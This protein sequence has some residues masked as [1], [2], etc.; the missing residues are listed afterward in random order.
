MKVDIITPLAVIKL[1]IIHAAQ[2][3]RFAKKSLGRSDSISPKGKELSSIIGVLD[4]N[5]LKKLAWNGPAS[6]HDKF[7]QSIP[8]LVD[9]SM[10]RSM[11]Q[12]MD[13]YR[14]GV[15]KQSESTMHTLTKDN[16]SRSDFELDINLVES[17]TVL[18]YASRMINYFFVLRAE[19][20][21]E[22]EAGRISETICRESLKKIIPETFI[23]KRRM[24]LNYAVLKTMYVQR[25]NHR[26]KEWKYFF[27]H[28][29]VLPNYCLWTG[30]SDII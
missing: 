19:I 22:R 23:Q 20:L 30:P 15:S 24:S 12:E 21:V 1:S 27:N 25:K 29:M 16:L 17:E 9:V 3:A 6:G 18:E 5:L 10:S 14:I 11:W 4:Y 8:F 28:L 2:G 7:L 13:T 26:N